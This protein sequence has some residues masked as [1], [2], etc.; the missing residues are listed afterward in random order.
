MKGKA[1][2]KL[3]NGF[4][5]RAVWLAFVF[6]ILASGVLAIQAARAETVLRVAMTAG[7]IPDWTGQPDQGFEGFRFVGWSLYD[8]FINWDLSRS[9]IEAP[10]RPALATKWY[11]DPANNKRWIFE[12]RKGVK[13]HD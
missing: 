8:S 9:D 3:V 2:P 6:G 5:A 4:R 12:L 7:D 13:F 1:M 10:L 11:I